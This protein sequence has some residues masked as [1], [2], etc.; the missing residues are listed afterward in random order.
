MTFFYLFFSIESIFIVT[1]LLFNKMLNNDSIVSEDKLKFRNVYSS[2]SP[3]S[4]SGK[5]NKVD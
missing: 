5:D 1:I 2:I 4:M 3:I